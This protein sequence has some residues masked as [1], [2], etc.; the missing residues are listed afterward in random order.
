MAVNSLII[1]ALVVSV[2]LST[3]LRSDNLF[4]AYFLQTEFNEPLEFSDTLQKKNDIIE[5]GGTATYD[6]R[7]ADEAIK[8]YRELQKTLKPGETY[9]KDAD[10]ILTIEDVDERLE[11]LEHMAELVKAGIKIDASR[12]KQQ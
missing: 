3:S 12:F 2:A 8:F 9:Q 5:Q 7:D 11:N 1:C 10:T 4:K 6:A